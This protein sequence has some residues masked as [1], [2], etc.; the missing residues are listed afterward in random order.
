MEK[1][2]KNACAPDVQSGI[3]TGTGRR[4]SEATEATGRHARSRPRETAGQ[5]KPLRDP[6]KPTMFPRSSTSESR[7]PGVGGKRGY[8]HPAWEL[9]LAETHPK[10]AGKREQLSTKKN[11]ASADKRK[12]IG[13]GIAL[14]HGEKGGYVPSVKRVGRWQSKQQR[15]QPSCRSM[16]PDFRRRRKATRITEPRHKQ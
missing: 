12:T 9:A 4:L 3:Y 14:P 6:K 5:T 7:N 15:Y 1:E 11:G 16:K 2:V 13:E 10:Q 8:R